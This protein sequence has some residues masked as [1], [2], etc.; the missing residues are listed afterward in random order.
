MQKCKA[1]SRGIKKKKKRKKQNQQLISFGTEKEQ[2][3]ELSEEPR[4]LLPIIINQM[5]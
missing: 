3:S 4:I 1:S 5:M 2:A